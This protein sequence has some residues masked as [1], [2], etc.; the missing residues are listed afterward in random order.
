[1][2]KYVFR[3]RLCGTLCGD[4]LEPLSNVTVRLYGL[5]SGQ[6]ATRLAVADPKTTLSVLA[7]AEIQ[8]KRSALLGEFQ[9]DANGAFTATFGERYQGEAF[10]IDVYCGTVPHGPPHPPHGPVQF[11]I[12]TLQPQWRQREDMLLAG[13]DYCLPA[14]FWCHIRALFD[15]WVICGHVTVCD[16]RE[17]VEGVKV[18]AFDRD[19]LQDDPLGFGFTDAAGHFRIDYTGADFR[20]GTFINIELFGGPDVYFRIESASGDVLLNEPPNTGRSP[21]RENIG[22]CFCVELCIKTSPVVRH[23][24]FTRV[25]DF[26]IYSDIDG[27]TGLTTSAQPAGFPNAHGGPGFGFWGS[28]KLVGDCPT[29]HPAGGQPMRY[30]FLYRPAGSAATATPITG[31][32]LVDAVKVGTRPVTWNFGGGVGVFPQDVYVAGSG[33]YVGPMPAPFPPPPP[34]PPPGSWG[35][36]PALILQPDAQGWVTMPPD[37]TNQ[38]FSGPLLRLHSASIS[39][40]GTPPTVGPGNPVAGASQKS[41]LDFEIVFEAE[42][43]TGPAPSGPTLGNSLPRIHINNWF[44]DAE[45][46]LTQLNVDACSPITTAVDILYTMDHELVRG[47]QLSISTSAVIPGGTPALPGLGVITDPATQT[48]TVRGGNGAVHLNTGTW[49]QCAYAVIFSRVL[50]LTDGE[51]DDSGRSPLVAIFCK[52]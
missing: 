50:K 11:S 7:E 35:S 37:A 45:F 5:R 19:W 51:I 28:L 40:G 23:A 39:S 27:A 21:G 46:S 43:T 36:M 9:T 41:G 42:P 18:F 8:A 24:W 20:R 3:G 49:P 15:A 34:G 38:G 26:N 16:S 47:W 10:E 2:A 48:E 22:P 6:D 13:W 12:T 44:E 4:C 30:R 17:P 25:G 31:A 29:T 14:Q 33:G 1:M 32:G 52:H